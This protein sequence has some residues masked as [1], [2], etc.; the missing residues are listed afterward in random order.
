MTA[1]NEW[2]SHPYFYMFTEWNTFH[3]TTTTNLK[4]ESFTTVVGVSSPLITKHNYNKLYV[5]KSKYTVNSTFDSVISHEFLLA[6][7]QLQRHYCK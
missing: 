5:N 6:W 7:L 1:V 3:F 2:K 4:Y